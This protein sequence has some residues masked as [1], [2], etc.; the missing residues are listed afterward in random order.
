[1]S[2]QMKIEEIDKSY[3]THQE[4]LKHYVENTTGENRVWK[5]SYA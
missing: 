5:H 4:F 1:M 2:N 3:L